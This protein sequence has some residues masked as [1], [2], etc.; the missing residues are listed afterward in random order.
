MCYETRTFIAVITTLD[1][2][3]SQWNTILPLKTHLP[4]TSS[5]IVLS[6]PIVSQVN[7]SLQ[8]L[9][10]NLCQLLI[11]PY[12]W[13]MCHAFHSLSFHRNNNIV[14]K[15]TKAKFL[16]ITFIHEQGGLSRVYTI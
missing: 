15:S 2:I 14:L 16:V 8:A 6:T 3:P 13:Y 7:S 5:D 1:R 4:K 10:S 12:L 9:R 11:S